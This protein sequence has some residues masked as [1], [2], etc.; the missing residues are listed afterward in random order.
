MFIK[1]DHKISTLILR[2]DEA[3]HDPD[4]KINSIVKVLR[5]ASRSKVNV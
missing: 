5:F 2:I 4:K 3:L 1:L